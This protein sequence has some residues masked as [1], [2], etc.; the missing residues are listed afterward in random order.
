MAT[1][2]CRVSMVRGRPAGSGGRRNN[3]CQPI[4]RSLVLKGL[5]RSGVQ[6][7]GDDVEVDLVVDGQAGALGKVLTQETV[8]VLVGAA[9]PRRSRVAE[10]DGHVGGEGEALV[11]G[12]LQ[13]AVPGEAGAQL[14]GQGLHLRR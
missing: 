13:A 4:S 11:V 3:A 10:V 14:L 12:E 5:A 6:P 1:S 9:L 2:I 7:G 8:G